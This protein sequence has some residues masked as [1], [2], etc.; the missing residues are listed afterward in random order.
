M[1][2][3]GAEVRRSP[4]VCRSRNGRGDRA[5]LGLVPLWGENALVRVVVTRIEQD[6]TMQRRLVLHDT[7]RRQTPPSRLGLAEESY[8]FVTSRVDLGGCKLTERHGFTQR[9]GS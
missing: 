8:R 3:A 6:G 4:H 9:H 5:G 1:H 2:G 7:E